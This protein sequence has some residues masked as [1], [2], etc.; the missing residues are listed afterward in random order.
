MGFDEQQLRV[1]KAQVI[2]KRREFHEIID[3]A[4]H[5]AQVKSGNSS[6]RWNSFQGGCRGDI[7]NSSISMEHCHDD[8]ADYKCISG[9]ASNIDQTNPG[10]LTTELTHISNEDSFASA[11]L[12][13]YPKNP[14]LESG[15]SSNECK[16]D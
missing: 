13:Y 1:L 2:A 11:F 10:G 12:Y 4:Y 15:R 5:L 9:G 8:F 14:Q 3:R 7:Q 6:E 16:S